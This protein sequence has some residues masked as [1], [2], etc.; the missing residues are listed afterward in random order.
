[1]TMIRSFAAFA[2]FVI[3]RSF[4]SFA[5]SPRKVPQL[6]GNALV[7]SHFSAACL[8]MSLFPDVI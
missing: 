1:M 3:R 8:A 6:V 2:S 7:A 4:T 5:V